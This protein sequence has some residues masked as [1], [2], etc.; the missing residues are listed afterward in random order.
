MILT[1]CNCGEKIACG[2]GTLSFDSYNASAT[3]VLEVGNL[4]ATG[5]TLDEY[6]IDWYRD[7]VHALVSGVGYDP[8]IDAFHPMTGTN[9]VPVIGGTWV[10]VIRYIVVGGV[11]IF[12]EPRP[13]KNWCEMTISLPAS[14]TVERLDCGKTNITGSFQYQIAYRSTDPISLPSR[15]IAWDLPSDQSIRYFAINFYGYDVTDKIEVFL[16]D[17]STLLVAWTVG[18]NNPTNYNATPPHHAPYSSSAGFQFTIDLPEY[19]AGDFLLIKITPSFFEPTVT[20]TDWTLQMKCLSTFT[21]CSAISL[22]E[23]EFADITDYSWYNNVA[24]CQYELRWPLTATPLGNLGTYA[25][26]SVGTFN[27]GVYNESY[28]FRGLRLSYAKAATFKL[29]NVIGSKIETAGL[30]N[31]TKSGNVLTYTFSEMADYNAVLGIYN[32]HVASAAY[33]DFV[34]DP[35]DNRYYAYFSWNWKSR[36]VGCGDDATSPFRTLRFHRK[37]TVVFSGNTCTITLFNV[38]LGLSLVDCDNLT[39]YCKNAVDYCSNTYWLADFNENSYCFES[40]QLQSYQYPIRSSTI[41]LKSDYE[42]GASVGIKGNNN[43]C[44]AGWLDPLVIGNMSTPAS[45]Y[46]FKFYLSFHTEAEVD[47]ATADYYRDE[48]GEYIINPF[49]NFTVWNGIN[50]ST[51]MYMN[52]TDPLYRSEKLLEVSGGVVIYPPPLS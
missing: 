12:T 2:C 10:P 1:N 35:T 5:C 20:A 42:G 28:G 34:D 24:L 31:L 48:F 36:P 19:G 18:K 52:S 41:Y 7:G 21:G 15:T 43:P 6:V 46:Y 51:Q 23:R 38:T 11:Q 26:L 44:F 13:C 33:A 49:E 30:V 14:I 4:V 8:D 50:P 9:A 47:P 37:S 25:G 16:N 22:A 17:E 45:W 40:N 32:T 29:S 39:T 3:S 27:S